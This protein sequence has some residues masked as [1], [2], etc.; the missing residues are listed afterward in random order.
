MASPF[1]ATQVALVEYIKRE[2]G[3]PVVRLEIT[4][5]QVKDQINK[6]LQKFMEVA[7]GGM[8]ARL[9]L[10][11]ALEGQQE[12]LLPY[13]VISVLRVFTEQEIITGFGTSSDLFSANQYVASDMVRG[14]FLQGN[15]LHIELY[16][17]WSATMELKLGIK[18]DYDF[19]TATKNF[20]LWEKPKKDQVYGCVVWESI[21]P[22]SPEDA[23]IFDHRWIKEYAVEMCRRQWG[24]NLM[25]YEGSALP[26][27]L[28]LNSA[29]LISE[30]KENLT[31]LE[32]DLQ[33]MYQLPPDFFIGSWLTPL[34]LTAGS[35]LLSGLI[36]GIPIPFV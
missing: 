20:Y 26:A 24:Y 23:N 11:S 9:Y 2:L 13:E 3:S 7:Y 25:K 16:N 8:Q 18:K 21:D 12:Y 30:A 5:E 34:I 28:A 17:Q 33:E 27:G 15:L 1:L 10:L 35:A 29:A 22:L 6:A 32:A 19:N 31:P 4:N 36:T 14:G